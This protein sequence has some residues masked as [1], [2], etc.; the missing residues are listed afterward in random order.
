MTRTT[1]FRWSLLAQLLNLQSDFR[2]LK[3]NMFIQEALCILLDKRTRIR[4]S[5]SFKK[6]L[7]LVHR[8]SHLPCPVCGEIS[9]SAGGIHP[10]CSVRQADADR[11]HRI[12]KA[13]EI[14]SAKK[15]VTILSVWQ[16]SCPQCQSTLH[17]WRT[18]CRCGFHFKVNASVKAESQRS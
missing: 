7:P 6:P 13:R 18:N 5:M 17:V 16:K 14:K 10:Q 4:L 8:E 2:F 12:K 15:P 3:S 11:M 1:G 9:Y